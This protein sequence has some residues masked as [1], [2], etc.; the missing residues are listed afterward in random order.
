MVPVTVLGAGMFTVFLWEKEMYLLH[1][2]NVVILV[3]EKNHS[4]VGLKSSDGF[5]GGMLV[6]F[7]VWDRNGRTGKET[8]WLCLRSSQSRTYP[9]IWVL[10]GQTCHPFQKGWCLT[11]TWRRTLK[12][13]LGGLHPPVL[14]EVFH[15]AGGQQSGPMFSI[16][17]LCGECVRG[18]MFQCVLWVVQKWRGRILAGYWS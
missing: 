7:R 17:K 1:C 18:F 12:K 11:H 14:W 15:R 13:P 2:H 3:M 9:V 10:T 6:R 16:A 4:L 8:P 5:P